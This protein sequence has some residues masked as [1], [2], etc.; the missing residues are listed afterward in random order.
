MKIV[1]HVLFC[2]LVIVAFG[3]K[4]RKAAGSYTADLY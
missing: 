2:L 3:C 4:K 1:K